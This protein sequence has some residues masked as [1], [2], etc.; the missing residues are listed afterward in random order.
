MHGGPRWARVKRRL[1]A[2]FLVESELRA[3]ERRRFGPSD[4]GWAEY[5]WARSALDAADRFRETV[6]GER[7]TLLL[8]QDA[9]WLACLATAKRTDESEVEP[10]PTRWL[11]DLEG[12]GAVG[13][14]IDGLSD[15]DREGLEQVLTKRCAGAA[16]VA[17]SDELNSQIQRLRPL[18]AA[19]FVP[20]DRDANSIA[21]VKRRRV[22]RIG[23]AVLIVA[24]CVVLPAV[25][26]VRALTP[27]P[28][29]HALH[30]P[31][32]L[33]SAASSERTSPQGLVDGDTSRVAAQTQ[34]QRNPWMRIDLGRSTE[35]TQ[36]VVH[37]AK[38]KKDRAQA[39]P[40]VVQVSQD[41][42]Q[43]R[44]L[45]RQ[46]KPFSVWKVRPDK[47]PVRA[48]YVRLIT[49]KKKKTTLRLSEVEV[50]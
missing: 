19:W 35:I 46:S 20:L 1:A 10:D 9:L 40:L 38:S 42:K 14:G 47:S 5:L 8:L 41:R 32:V 17:S 36:I 30:R 43:W 21:R 29:N 33:S 28:T 12:S 37:S 23:G 50:Y 31:V 7:A 48:R 15:T 24:A 44:Q 45:A 3:A 39:V 16:S 26:L 22:L 27:Q 2:Y 6:N 34:R 11:G 49:K 13:P 4:P 25:A 18:A